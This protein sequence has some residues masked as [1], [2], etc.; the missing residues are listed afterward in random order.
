MGT[1]GE[2]PRPAPS[3]RLPKQVRVKAGL[4][5]LELVSLYGHGGRG[6]LRLQ[7]VSGPRVED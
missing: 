7:P 4:S 2:H 1:G 5:E 3:R 6:E